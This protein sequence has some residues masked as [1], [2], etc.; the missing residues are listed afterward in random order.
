[1]TYAADYKSWFAFSGYKIEAQSQILEQRLWEI[2]PQRC[3]NF[4]PYFIKDSDGLKDFLE[5][6]MPVSVETH[7]EKLGKFTTVIEWLKVWVKIRW[8]GKI[9]CV[10]DD[11]RMWLYEPDRNINDNK[12]ENNIIWNISDQISELLYLPE[13]VNFQIPLTGVFRAP[14]STEIIAGFLNEFQRF[15]WFRAATE[16]SWERRAGFDLFTLRLAQGQQK[17]ELLMQPEKYPGQDFGAIIEDVFSGL[18]KEG[19]NHIIDATY[20]GKIL[21]RNLL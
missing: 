9:W 1:M 7:M 15:E 21:L 10:S 13:G 14:F 16:I 17:F 6:D 18:V 4:W 11:G 8:R 19:G 2:F 5:L 3:L 12:A 20:E